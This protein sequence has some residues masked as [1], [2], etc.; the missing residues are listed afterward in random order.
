ML[1]ELRMPNK[2]DKKQN[3]DEDENKIP[4]TKW[5]CNRALLNTVGSAGFNELIS[6]YW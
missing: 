2:S 4:K 5:N 3:K 1:T 6:F